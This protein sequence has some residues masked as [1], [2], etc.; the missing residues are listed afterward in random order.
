MIP[1][2]GTGRW[3]RALAITAYVA[4]ALVNCTRA[5]GDAHGD[6]IVTIGGPVTE[7]VFALGAGPRVVAVDTSSVYPDAAMRL[8]QVGY[9]RTL[10]A[11]GI[12]AQR[13]ALVIAGADAGPPAVLE[14]LRAAGVRVELVANAQAPETAAARIEA[15]GRLI[16]AEPR[17]HALAAQVLAETRAARASLPAG[18]PRAIAIYARGA[19]TLLVAGGDTTA[20]AMLGLAGATNAATGFTGYKP[21]SAEAL[22]AAAPD[23][24]VVPARGLATI[25]GEAGLLALPGVAQTPAGRARKI[26]ALDDLELLG[27]G[28]RLGH[29]IA[30]LARRMR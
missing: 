18:S 20:G 30:E 26:V 22:I 13:P 14:Q 23:V 10:A 27:F 8:P 5:N 19:G 28:P 11:E 16:G 29:S 4:A 6:R 9:Q 24:I 25:G 1:D 15:V 7:I 17:A 2:P 12:L 21:L 3:W